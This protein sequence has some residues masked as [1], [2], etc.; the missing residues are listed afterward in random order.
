MNGGKENVFFNFN[1][2]QD[3]D[4]KLEPGKPYALRYR[5]FVYDGTISTDK[6]EQLWYDFAYP[7]KVE[8][9]VLEK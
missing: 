5:M 6:A 3:R 2:T 7:P 9:N 4:W 8:L 1:P